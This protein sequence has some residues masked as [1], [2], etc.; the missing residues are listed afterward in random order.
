MGEA[1][2]SVLAQEQ[3][4]FELIVVDDASTD[5]T[6]HVLEKF[7][8]AIRIIK[9]DV[10][11][12]VGAARNAG[13]QAAT[14]AAF[15]FLDADDLWHPRKLAAQLSPMEEGLATVTGIDYC[16]E[17]GKPL[18]RQHR[19]VDTDRDDVFVRNPFP[20]SGST[21][22]IPRDVFWQLGGFEEEPRGIAEDWIMNIRLIQEAAKFR[23]VSE[24][25]ARIRVHPGSYFTVAAPAIA[26]AR[27]LSVDW[28]ERS[29]LANRS[30]LEQARVRGALEI[31]RMFANHGSWN[32]AWAWQRRCL[33]Y[34][35]RPKLLY[36][37][38]SIT[39]AGVRGLLRRLATR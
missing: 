21:L 11:R 24:P 1:V 10:N 13:A 23:V 38:L 31:A 25:L 8:S 9:N 15:A 22:L 36:L 12:G 27:W 35:G 34:E 4:S 6:R 33:E 30:E 39:T 3:V 16:D 37:L 14:G 28:I 5:R 29:G 20:G 17:L 18:H 2:V 7:G 19:P 26:A 32:E